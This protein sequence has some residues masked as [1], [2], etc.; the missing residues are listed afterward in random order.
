M[1]LD[2]ILT[3]CINKAIVDTLQKTGKV[4]TNSQAVDIIKAQAKGIQ[5]GME[6]KDTIKIDELGRFEIKLGREELMEASKKA[7]AEN[8]PI[9]Q[10]RELFKSIIADLKK[11]QEINKNGNIHVG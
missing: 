8:M 4:V 10:R 11:Q 2:F 1:F 5:V 7:K 6:S 3:N 9:E